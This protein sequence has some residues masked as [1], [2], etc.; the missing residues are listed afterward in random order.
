MMIATLEGMDAVRDHQMAI[1][2]QCS[3]LIDE[4]RLSLH[5]SE[6]LTLDQ[7]AGAHRKIEAGHTVGKWVLKTG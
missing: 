7:A 2:R 1:L 6:V 5:V 3:G 4:S